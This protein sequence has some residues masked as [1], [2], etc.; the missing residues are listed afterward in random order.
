MN[1]TEGWRKWKP[2]EN[3]SATYYID[4][5]IGDIENFNILLTD[6]NDANKKIKVI[7]EISVD[8]YRVIDESYRYRT[9]VKLVE[10]Y[11][12]KFI[13]DW[14]FF[15]VDNSNFKQWLSEES[16]G[17]LNPEQFTHFSF[18]GENCIVDVVTTYEPKIEFTEN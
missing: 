7:F 1:K 8:A 13:N 18:I 10:K 4:S 16:F 9:I 15:K 12:E 5:I 11:G 2:Q 17:F 14:T 6:F 3:L